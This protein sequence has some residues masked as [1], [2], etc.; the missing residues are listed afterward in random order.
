M[1]QNIPVYVFE[2]TG[3][4]NASYQMRRPVAPNYRIHIIL[5]LLTLF[6][7]T[8]A[9]AIM[10]A[11]LPLRSSFLKLFSPQFMIHGLSFSIPLMSILLTHE[12]GHY[13]SSRVHRVS[14]SLPYFIPAPTFIG[15]FGAFIKMK[16]PI[17]TKRALIDIG[18]AGP[19]AGFI[20]SVLAIIIGLKLSKVVP[21][22]GTHNIQIGTSLLIGLLTHVFAK[23][24]PEGYDLV[25]H[26][27]GFAG[28]IGLFVTSLNLIPVGQLDGGHIAY[29]VLGKRYEKM[30]TL[31]IMGLI[32]MSLFWR[33]WLIWALILMFMGKKHPPTLN[34]DGSLDK[35]RIILGIVMLVI[36]LITFIPVPF[37]L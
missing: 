5:F 29:A 3:K 10:A 2:Q 21:I 6:T 27:I 12:M 13:I 31:I 25:I 7:T 15:T 4:D 36:F 30:T 11:P 19:I 18:A 20:L 23:I 22:S 8:S 24:P 35:N 26:P 14:A 34:T 1:K 16:S 28:W 33:G 17:F 9:G 37:K 32:G